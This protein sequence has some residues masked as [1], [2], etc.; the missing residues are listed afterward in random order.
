MYARCFSRALSEP[1]YRNTSGFVTGFFEHFGE[2]AAAR[3]V[4]AFVKAGGNLDV[5]L[6]IFGPLSL[7][8]IRTV[9]LFIMTYLTLFND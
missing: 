1:S 8:E 5:L 6:Q 2:E 7:E 4:E 9:R 3:T